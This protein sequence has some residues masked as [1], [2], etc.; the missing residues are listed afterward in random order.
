[1]ASNRELTAAV[2]SGGEPEDG[3]H[4]AR[5]RPPRARGS[6]LVQVPVLSAVALLL[7]A[8]C[9]T[10]GGNMG[11]PSSCTYKDE[12][13]AC[14]RAGTAP[15]CGDIPID[16]DGECVDCGCDKGSCEAC[17]SCADTYGCFDECPGPTCADFRS[18]LEN[19]DDQ[20]SCLAMCRTQFAN[21]ANDTRPCENSICM[22]TCGCV[23]GGC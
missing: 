23:N 10:G 22:V 8:S 9:G 6:G 21:Q 14:C 13:G 11:S 12:S 16:R 3:E 7:W 15:S 18:C 1:M 19:C 5:T 17:R 4:P 20:E 2:G